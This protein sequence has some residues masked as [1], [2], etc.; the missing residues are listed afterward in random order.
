[1][2]KGLGKLPWQKNSNGFFLFSSP[3]LDFTKMSTLS[4]FHIL[5]LSSFAQKSLALKLKIK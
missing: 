2:I 5:L 3:V 1:M 4:D